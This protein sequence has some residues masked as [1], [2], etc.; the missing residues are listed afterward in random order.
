MPP[1]SMSNDLDLVTATH[2]EWPTD[3]TDRPTELDASTSLACTVPN[4][5]S[6]AGKP[7]PSAPSLPPKL[8]GSCARK[9]GYE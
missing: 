2:Y 3:A 6:V 9:P 1:L 7:L 5:R 4:P 8:A